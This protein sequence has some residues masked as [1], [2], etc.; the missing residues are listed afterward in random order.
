[1][2]SGSVSVQGWKTVPICQML[3]AICE[4]IAMPGSSVRTVVGKRCNAGVL[5]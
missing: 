2:L 5:N 4:C 3:D 1:M